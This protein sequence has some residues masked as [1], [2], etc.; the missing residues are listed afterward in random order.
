MVV[1]NV[2]HQ[3]QV[4]VLVEDRVRKQ[5]GFA[6]ACKVRTA[7]SLEY[8]TKG[9]ADGINLSD[10]EYEQSKN[11]S[12]MYWKTTWPEAQIVHLESS[13]SLSVQ[14]QAEIEAG[15]RVSN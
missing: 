6:L 13:G 11:E 8:L 7:D 5:I 12:E 4:L 3:R 14:M 10:A 1:I 15:K 9:T 2:V